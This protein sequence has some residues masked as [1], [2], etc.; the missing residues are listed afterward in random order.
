MIPTPR[1]IDVRVRIG[2]SLSERHDAA[3]GDLCE[4][5]ETMS[6]VC[7]ICRSAMGAKNRATPLTADRATGYTTDTHSER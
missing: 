6:S 5:D 3:Q 4:P 7:A 1:Q 2:A